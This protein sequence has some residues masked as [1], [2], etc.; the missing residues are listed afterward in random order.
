MFAKICIWRTGLQKDGGAAVVCS[1]NVEEYTLIRRVP[2]QRS[3]ATVFKLDG[4]H[5][6]WH[7]GSTAGNSF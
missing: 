5:D 7:I 2:G 4:D 6:G 1:T 3:Q